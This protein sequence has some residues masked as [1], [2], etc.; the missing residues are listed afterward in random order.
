MSMQ[1]KNYSRRGAAGFTL[2]E[3]IV[4]IML[5]AAIA[6]VVA[7]KVI[8]NKHRAEYNLAK[9]QLSSLAA[10]IDQYQADVGDYPDSLD[11]LVNAPSQADNWLGPYAKTEELKD[12]WHKPIEYRKPGADEAPYSLTSLGVDGKPG[13]DGVDKDL[14][15]P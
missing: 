15:A 10:Q 11:Q 13:G 9:T 2:I 8:Q 7:G 1:S 5:I 4:V 3:M 14:V 12:P 6:A